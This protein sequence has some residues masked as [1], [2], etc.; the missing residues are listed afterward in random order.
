MA[1]PDPKPIPLLTPQEIDRFWSHVD[2]SGGP[3]ACW[4]W[5]GPLSIKRYGLF[6]ITRNGTR[7]VFRSSRISLFLSTGRF[8]VDLLVCHHCDR[9]WCCNPGHLFTGTTGDN[10]KDALAKGLFP[11]GNQNWQNKFH[12][13]VPRG[14]RRCNSKLTD[15]IVREIRSR[16]ASGKTQDSLGREF[17]VC[18]VVVSK[19]VRR[20]LWDHVV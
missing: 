2:R 12:D 9:P 3:D 5:I 19:V 7:Q 11:K 17:G 6:R 15:S 8:P 13:L 4:P 20:Q 16:Y 10:M 18:Q 1:N 14:I